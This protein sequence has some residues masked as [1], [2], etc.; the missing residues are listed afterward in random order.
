MRIVIVVIWLA[1]VSLAWFGIGCGS[2]SVFARMLVVGGLPLLSK[3]RCTASMSRQDMLVGLA[4]VVV[5][6]ALIRWSAWSGFTAASHLTW[7]DKP[8]IRAIGLAAVAVPER[9]SLSPRGVR[10][11]KVHDIGSTGH[12]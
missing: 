4:T 3:R 11:S 10:A 7:L 6:F 9:R 12:A 5:L 2:D 1:V 8:E